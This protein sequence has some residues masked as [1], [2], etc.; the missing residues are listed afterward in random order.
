[1]L[2]GGAQAVRPREQIGHV[3]QGQI[4]GQL[5]AEPGDVLGTRPP[6]RHREA[7]TVEHGPHPAAH[8][9]RQLGGAIGFLEEVEDLLL[10][11]AE[12]LGQHLVHD[13]GRERHLRLGLEP[14]DELEGLG[15]GHLFGGGH[16]DGAGDDRIGE[17]I[18][19]PPGLVADPTHLDQIVD[20]LGS[21][22]LADHV[23]GGGGVDHDQVVVALTHLPGDL[24]HR[25]DLLDPGG[26]RGHEVERLRQR[27][28]ASEQ[29]D[30]Q[31]KA[32]VL[33]ERLLGVHRHGE[34]VRSELPRREGQRTRF[35]DIAQRALGV[36]L[37]EQGPLTPLRRQQAERGRHA[38]LAD[39]P[40]AGDEQQSSLEQLEPGGA[41]HGSRR[42]S[43]PAPKPIRRS[44][45]GLPISM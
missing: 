32:Q 20:R 28:D 1:M 44:L 7:G 36:D 12:Q 10:P 37:H 11:P 26:G 9:R 43:Q 25:E 17:Q 2:C 8:G 19:H 35:E 15:D 18:Q 40:L 39:A 5:V 4:G 29:R 3:Q 45:S 16:D 31:L 22:Q 42:R 13:D 14:I 24:A 30:P 21:R 27:P 23:T 41:D 6:Q 38:G 33:L 34:E